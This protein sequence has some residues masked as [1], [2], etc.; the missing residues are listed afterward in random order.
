M[1]AQHTPQHGRERAGRRMHPRVGRRGHVVRADG[2]R[3]GGAG[4]PRLDGGAGGV[5]EVKRDLHST[6][7]ASC[8]SLGARGCGA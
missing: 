4:L 2:E 5:G 6:Q 3:V 8:G 1:L 7:H